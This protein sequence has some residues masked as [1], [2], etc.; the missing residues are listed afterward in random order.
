MISLT[1][2]Q[3]GKADDSMEHMGADK[4]SKQYYPRYKIEY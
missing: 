2:L 4:V 1:A 3:F